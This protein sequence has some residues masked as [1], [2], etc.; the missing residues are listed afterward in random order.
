MNLN[1]TRGLLEDKKGRIW[2]ATYG[3]P[4]IWSPAKNELKTYVADFNSNNGLR[5]NYA[6]SIFELD[7]GTI[8]VNTTKG[9]HVAKEENGN[10]KFEFVR[11]L[12]FLSVINDNYLWS[13]QNSKLVKTDV[14]TFESSY[15][16]DFQV[17]GKVINLHSILFI[18]ENTAWLGASNGLIKYN[19]Q[20]KE[21]DFF[22]IKSNK[23]YPLISLVNDNF[24][25][26]WAS[27][28]SAILKFSTDIQTF[29][30]YPSG[31]EIPISRFT[32]GCCLK[33]KNGDLIFG[34]HDGFLKFAPEEITK[35]EFISP[36]KFTRLLISNQEINTNQ[37]ING[38]K[39]LE[40][41][42]A[43]TKNIT[44]D[45]AS[46]SFSLEFSSLQYGNRDGIR[47]AYMLEGEDFDWHYLNGSVGL[48]TY[49]NLSPGK[50]TLRVTGTNNDGVW[51][52]QETLLN[53]RVKPP[54]WASPGFIVVYFILFIL[55]TVALINY[56]SNRSKMQNELKIARLEKV[57]AEKI[58]QTRQQFFTNI[59]HE[60]RTPLSLI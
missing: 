58:A 53:I 15:E 9:L 56:Y 26:I 28:Y 30:I 13:L 27:S 52:K 14:V 17:E 59:P 4:V 12:S 47:Y 16:I 42:I 20:S 19:L 10:F 51:N 41:E 3:G 34:G 7:D 39:I 32:E 11:S 48:A 57:H 55:I 25:N 6:E 24:G 38:K 54:L 60:F 22:E 35:S 23:A 45:Y 33:S 46:G 40:Q 50:Y 8:F 1:V 21:F 36:V 31:D 37:E 2:I 29:D 43:F 44:Q 18:D 49:S 5:T